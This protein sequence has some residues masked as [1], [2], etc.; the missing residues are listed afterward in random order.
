MFP[1]WERSTAEIPAVS[2]DSQVAGLA[3]CRTGASRGIEAGAF[4]S[5]RLKGGLCNPNILQNENELGRE[6]TL[7]TFDLLDRLVTVTNV[8]W[9]G[10]RRSWWRWFV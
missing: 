5:D 3:R 10:R 1:G 6:A 2:A 4:K 7:T 9:I 8:R